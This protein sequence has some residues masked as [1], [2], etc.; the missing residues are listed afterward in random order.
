[1]Q[2]LSDWYCTRGQL[3][4][5]MGGKEMLNP[6][7]GQEAQLY[8]IEEHRL[9][10]GKGEGM[11]LLEINNG[12]GLEMTVSADRAA[13]IARLRV[14]GSNLSYFSPCGYVA[15]AYYQPTGS[16]WLKS[17]T[18]GFL[19]TC[20][21][22]AV[23]SPCVD[24]GEE[25]PLHGSVGN[26][27]AEYICWQEEEGELVV[28]AQ[29]RDEVIF[30]RKLRL[31]REIRVSLTEN[32]F[33]IRD[34]IENTGSTSQPVEILYHM[35]MGY[36]LLDEDSIVE[37]PAKEVVPRDEHAAED[38]VNCLKMEKPQPGY[39]ERCYYHKFADSAGRASIFQPKTGRKVTITFDAEKLDGFVEWKMMG[40]RDY[41]LGLECGNCYPDGRDVMRE[42]GMLKFLEPG[43]T[44]T[45]EVKIQVE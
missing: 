31:N 32:S 20:G 37:I 14:F 26:T 16:D 5:Y 1:M 8:G 19:T 41:V 12:K 6:Y 34:T 4:V 10:G 17:F 39:V 23:G 33:V 11:R 28:K 15:P 44:V 35:N 2:E 40:I 7:I 36:P 9:V 42:K 13:D 24:E 43:E 29:I 38:I 30:G 21:L 45:Y 3:P 25:L 18:A 22:Q 27:P